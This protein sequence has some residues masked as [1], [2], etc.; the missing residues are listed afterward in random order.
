MKMILSLFALSTSLSLF[1]HTGHPGP[2]SHGDMT[3]FTLGL[4]IGLPITL[5]VV[6]I[7]RGYVLK[8][9]TSPVKKNRS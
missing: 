5:A 1:A 3:H 7:L 4:L 9:Q 2:A 8:K 6:Y